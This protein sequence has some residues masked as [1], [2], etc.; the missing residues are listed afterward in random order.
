MRR[1]NP[2][3]Y[4]NLSGSVAQALPADWLSARCYL[5]PLRLVC[6]SLFIQ[7]RLCA[8]V[9]II[10]GHDTADPRVRLLW[11]CAIASDVATDAVNGIITRLLSESQSLEELEH[12]LLSVLHR[13]LFIQGSGVLFIPL[14]G[15]ALNSV[16]A[17]LVTRLTGQLALHLF[18]PPP[19][20]SLS[21]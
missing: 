9:A 3:C 16:A 10:G 5:S 4:M 13:E 2:L 14:P 15:G 20:P 6:T 17:W 11:W 7:M 1:L 8:S 19:S 21:A 12:A 18:I